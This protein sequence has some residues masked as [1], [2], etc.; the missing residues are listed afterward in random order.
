VGGGGV[1]ALSM[2]LSLSQRKAVVLKKVAADR[3]G[4]PEVLDE[5]VELSGWYRDYC[6]AAI[7]ATRPGKTAKTTKKQRAPRPP[8][9]G[10]A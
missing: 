5:L 6:R 2:E 10:S 8:L 7:R 4:K 1:D 3:A 9:Y